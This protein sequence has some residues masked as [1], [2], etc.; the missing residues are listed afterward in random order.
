MYLCGFLYPTYEQV[1]METRRG[2]QA[3]RT[4]AVVSHQVVWSSTRVFCKSSRGS[5]LSGE[6]FYHRNRKLGQLPALSSQG[7]STV[8]SSA[9]P[10][11]AARTPPLIWTLRIFTAALRSCAGSFFVNSM[12]IR[13][14]RKK[15]PQLKKSPD[16]ISLWLCL[17]GIFLIANWCMG[18]GCMATRE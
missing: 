4:W 1:P 10:L 14:L 5:L 15:N 3:P 13:P 6:M 18:A 16:Q 9:V 7:F 8:P 12:Q 2:H 11:A 17:W